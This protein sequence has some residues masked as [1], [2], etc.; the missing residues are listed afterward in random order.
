MGQGT[1][2][3]AAL[4]HLETAGNPFFVV[5]TLHAL[6]EQGVLYAEPGSG[7]RLRA[8]VLPEPTGLPVSD[9]VLRVIR[10]RIRRLS[11][12]AQ[13]V[14]TIAA[15]IEHDIDEK[16]LAR[17]VDPAVSLDLALDETLRALVLDETAPGLYQFSHIKVREIIYADTSA[18]RRRFLHRRTAELLAQQGQGTR[19]ADVS[20][21]G[22]HYA[23]AREWT[24]AL[25][26]TW[27]ASQIAWRAGAIAE[28]NRY[29]G[30]AQAILDEHEAELDLSDLPET[31]AAIRFD[32]LALRAEF[33][34]QTTTAGLYYPPDLLEAI[35]TL[36]PEVNDA[37]RAQAA[38]QQATHLLGQGDLAGAKDAAGRA[39]AFYGGDRWGELDAMQHQIDVAYRAGDM[40]TMRQLLDDMRELSAALD[41][42][43]IRQIVGVN[44]MRL[45]VYERDWMAVL[46]LAQELTAPQRLPV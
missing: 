15:V 37:R 23:Q 45:A 22:Y 7:W 35:H 44:E 31:L 34:R 11:R 24:P 1:R 13:E 20:K 16:L 4:L 12:A 17:L 30:T 43:D 41:Y 42:H 5:E 27:R 18:P 29:A 46:R 21:L 28:A 39:R 6:I 32:L 8:D 36:L 14:L 38:L 26:H 33:R 19:L 3:L 40:V 9:V 25:A 2:P 10:G